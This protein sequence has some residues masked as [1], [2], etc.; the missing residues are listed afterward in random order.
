MGS[1]DKITECRQ[2]ESSFILLSKLQDSCDRR[3]QKEDKRQIRRQKEEK[4]LINTKEDKRPKDKIT[5]CRQNQKDI[6]A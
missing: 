1:K 3:R 2:M 5:E 4:R 6:L